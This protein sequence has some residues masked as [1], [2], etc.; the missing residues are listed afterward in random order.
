[1]FNDYMW[2]TYLNAGGKSAVSLFEQSLTGNLSQD[3][4]ET[5]G[6]FRLSYCPEKA[7]IEETAQQLQD[8]SKDLND[9]LALLESGEYT[10]DSAMQFLYNGIKGEE[11][12]SAQDVFACFSDSIEYFTTSL[13]AEI[14]DLFTP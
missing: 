9:N 6:K 8:L 13:A 10:I 14:P 12:C 3:Y 2:Q 7:I 1:M 11:D 4:I 5:I